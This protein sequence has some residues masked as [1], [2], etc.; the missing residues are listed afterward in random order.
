[1]EG[2]QKRRQAKAGAH[3]THRTCCRTAAPAWRGAGAPEQRR[4]IG[5]GGWIRQGRLGPGRK[6]Q[7]EIGKQRGRKRVHACQGLTSAACL[8]DK[9]CCSDNL[10]RVRCQTRAKQEKSAR[11]RAGSATS[12]GGGR[13]PRASALCAL[14]CNRRCRNLH[15]GS[16]LR[17]HAARAAPQPASTQGGLGFVVVSAAGAVR[18]A[19]ARRARTHASA[20]L[21]RPPQR[22]PAPLRGRSAGCRWA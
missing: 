15:G 19:A 16:S 8:C 9:V 12:R 6:E 18:R 11:A 3:A 1:M 7:G 14:H 22:G 20:Q 4:A 13:L 5:G 2:V 10:R 17:R 21:A